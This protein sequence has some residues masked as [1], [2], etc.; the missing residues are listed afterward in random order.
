[1][2]VYKTVVKNGELLNGYWEIEAREND[3]LLNGL[4]EARKYNTKVFVFHELG[5]PDFISH[6]FSES[7]E[8]L[9]A[10]CDDINGSIAF[11]LTMGVVHGGNN[12]CSK[13]LGEVIETNSK[14]KENESFNKEIKTLG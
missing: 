1:M 9:Q 6:I 14:L 13:V 8:S 10:L 12:P 4:E 3:W 7:V 2:K 11:W 5:K